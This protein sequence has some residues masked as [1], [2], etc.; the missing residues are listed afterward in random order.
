M[1]KILKVTVGN[2]QIRYLLLALCE[3]AVYPEHSK[4]VEAIIKEVEAL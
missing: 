2:G 4:P 3:L 1:D